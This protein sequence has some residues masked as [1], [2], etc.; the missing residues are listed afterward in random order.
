MTVNYIRNNCIHRLS[1]P[2]IIAIPPCVHIRIHAFTKSYH[3]HI[4]IIYMVI[5][6]TQYLHSIP[7]L[8]GSVCHTYLANQG[9]RSY[10]PG[11]TKA[12]GLSVPSA[13]V[14]ARFVIVSILYTQS[15]TY[16]LARHHKLGVL[17]QPFIGIHIHI[18]QLVSISN[19]ILLSSSLLSSSL[20]LHLH[21]RLT[22]HTRD[23]V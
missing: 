2:I 18:S 12:S 1:Y 9:S 11:P 14:C 13:E 15:Y 6:Y 7:N 4:H 22:R 10:I 23:I 16:S 19:L 8:V 20:S 17:S 3:T 21:Y 5:S